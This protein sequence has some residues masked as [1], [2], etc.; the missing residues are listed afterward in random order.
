MQSS[1]TI[2]S[3]ISNLAIDSKV[4]TL[5]DQDRATWNSEVV[6]Q[7]FLPHEALVIMG[8]L[9]SKRCTLDHIVGAHTP[10]GMFITSSAYKMLVSC[11][12][13][14]NAGHSSPEAQRHF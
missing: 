7:L 12:S 2:I 6:Q 8:I 10:S 5:I 13:T 3:P 11:D 4:N 9:L 14:S 1:R